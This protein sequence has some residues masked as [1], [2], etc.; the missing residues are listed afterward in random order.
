MKTFSKKVIYLLLAPLIFMM[1][2]GCM[3]KQSDG[4]YHTKY[5]YHPYYDL[6]STKMAGSKKTYKSKKA[7]HS[8]KS[9]SSSKVAY[10]NENDYPSNVANNSY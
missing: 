4:K 5:S 6:Y 9:L 3:P 7:S 1:L 2:N 10:N 8:S